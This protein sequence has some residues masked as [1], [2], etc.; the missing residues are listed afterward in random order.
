M[1]SGHQQCQCALM[2]NLA[3][4]LL[5]PLSA[6]TQGS[7]QRLDPVRT[8]VRQ[9][10]RTSTYKRADVDLNADGR[11][12]SFV[13]V[14]DPSFCGSGGCL[15]LVLSHRRSG[16]IVVM[17]TTLTKLPITVLR[18]VAHG[19]RDVAVTVQGDGIIRPYMARMRFNGHRYPSNPTMPP[20]VPLRRISGEVL[21]GS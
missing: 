16:Y 11:K 9:M 4:A 1:E 21:I 17:R 8:F 14:T 6:T 18:T 12:E 7:P 5:L 19:W 3:L 20:A 10:L 15:L 2:R 13:Y